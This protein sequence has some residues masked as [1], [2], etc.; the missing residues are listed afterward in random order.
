MSDITIS[1]T[2][3]QLA[4]ALNLLS[5]L[6]FITSIFF[7]V[8]I[9]KKV[10]E[11]LSRT[12]V[13]L[14]ITSAGMIL[15]KVLAILADIDVINSFVYDSLIVV[16]AFFFLLAVISFYKSIAQQIKPKRAPRTHHRVNHRSVRR[17]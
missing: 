1:I 4:V 6:F 2:S 7:L 14:I 8:W 16:S 10:A 9:K 5:I 12:F 3:S 11:N 13:Y 17:R 15:V